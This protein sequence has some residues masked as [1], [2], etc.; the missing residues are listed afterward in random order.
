MVEEQRNSKIGYFWIGVV[1]AVFFLSSV[2]SFI[3]SL[4]GLGGLLVLIILI[5]IFG[6]LAIILRKNS[7]FRYILLG[8]FS[9]IG[10]SLIF[11]GTCMSGGMIGSKFET[12]EFAGLNGLFLSLPFAIGFAIWFLIAISR[13]LSHAVRE[14][15][16]N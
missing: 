5:A 3:M 2:V 10:A 12:G 8:V 14:E 13:K 4:F 1:I 7:S 6:W 15:Q 11:F 16:E 9:A